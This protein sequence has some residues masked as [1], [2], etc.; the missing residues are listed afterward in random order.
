MKHIFV[1]QSVYISKE[2]R[3]TFLSKF[4]HQRKICQKKITF[5]I[6][7]IA[8]IKFLKFIKLYKALFVPIGRKEFKF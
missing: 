4:C 6:K 5:N 1:M 8:Y 7:F 3:N 2:H